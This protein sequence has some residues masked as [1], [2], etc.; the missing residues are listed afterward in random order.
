[1]TEE[2]LSL[3]SPGDTVKLVDNW[4]GV[5]SSFNINGEMDKWLGKYLTVE[6]VVYDPGNIEWYITVREDYGDGP[7]YQ[8]GHWCWYADMID[9]EVPDAEYEIAGKNDIIKFLFGGASS[10]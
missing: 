4:D 10:V 5:K 9:M 8:G 3:L 2:E 1:M 7:E 6:A